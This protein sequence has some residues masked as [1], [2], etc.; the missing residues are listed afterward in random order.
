L[1]LFTRN[2]LIEP[3]HSAQ[4][5]IKYISCSGFEAGFMLNVANNG[6][7]GTPGNGYNKFT[8]TIR[9]LNQQAGCALAA[10][11]QRFDSALTA[12]L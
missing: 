2:S 3:L 12:I 6:D 10:P 5:L 7:N 4:P 11:W 1:I 8:I 9:C